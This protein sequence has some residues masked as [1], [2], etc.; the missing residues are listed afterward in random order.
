MNYSLKSSS[1][2][3]A[4]L[5][6]T[7]H[8]KGKLECKNKL[9]GSLISEYIIWCLMGR[10]IPKQ[11]KCH[12]KCWNTPLNSSPP[13]IQC[14]GTILHPFQKEDPPNSS[15]KLKITSKIFFKKSISAKALLF[16]L[17]PNRFYTFKPR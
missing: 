5:N 9:L 2:E 4:S 6:C 15:V 11:S 13:Q 7:A 17:L 14:H 3:G 1:P 12:G 16:F 8:Q 10:K